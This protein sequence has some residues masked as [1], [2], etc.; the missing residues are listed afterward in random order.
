MKKV[1]PLLI[2]ITAFGFRIIVYVSTTGSVQ[3]SVKSSETTEI[4]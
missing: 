1:L 4:I 2:F 3:S